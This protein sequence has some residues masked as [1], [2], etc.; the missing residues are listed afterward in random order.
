MSGLD[1]TVIPLHACNNMHF[2]GQPSYVNKSQRLTNAILY[3]G[4]VVIGQFDQTC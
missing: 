4:A 1:F 2:C 3:S